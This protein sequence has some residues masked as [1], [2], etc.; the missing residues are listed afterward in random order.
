M[1]M[2]DEARDVAVRFM[3]AMH[4]EPRWD[5]MDQVVSPEYLN[6][7]AAADRSPGLE[8]AKET[9]VWLHEAFSDLAFEIE[10][11]VSDGTKVVIRGMAS[12][13][14]T[15][16]AGPLKHVPITG[17]PFR[18]QQIH[19]FAVAGGLVTEHWACRDDLGQMGQ[20]GM[21]PPRPQPPS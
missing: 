18:V 9:V 11:V 8:G 6:H 10:D 4:G 12:G 5:V 20:L 19:I 7:E 15:G 13:R 14:H 21:L 1:T 3:E 2:A 16:A 17:R